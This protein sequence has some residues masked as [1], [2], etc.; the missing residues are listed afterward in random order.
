MLSGITVV[1]FTRHLAGPYCTMRLADL[2]A[3]VIKIEAFP[4]GDPIRTLAP[5]GVD[6]SAYFLSANRNKKS[7][8]L[9]LHDPEGKEIAF[10]LA[11]QADV[12]IESFR[13]GVMQL[14]GL[15]YAEIQQARPDLIYCSLTGYGQSGPMQQL[16]GHDLNYQAVSGFLAVNRDELARPILAEV[17]IADFATG[18][19][20]AEQICAAL[21]QR[22]KRGV[23]TYLDIASVDILSSWMGIHALL[24]S[25]GQD[26]LM[27]EQSRA[28][29]N[30]G[31]YE[32]ADG[33]YVALAAIEEKFW[34]NF[35]R[36]VGR[37]DW[38]ALHNLHI[39]THPDIHEEVKALFLSR[40]QAEWHELGC[41]V[42]CCLT[43][44]EEMDTWLSS[45]YVTSRQLVFTLEGH[46]GEKILQVRTT[47]AEQL[48]HMT[49]PPVLGADT[50]AILSEKLQFTSDKIR[51]YE[52][53]GIIP[54]RVD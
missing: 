34:I 7:I 29:I 8:S 20:A 32:T 1:D 38:E 13:P 12:V 5:G 23:G 42:D 10:A 21:V 53:L 52:R 30:H 15:D 16:G 37:E 48:E 27:T 46:A 54:K 28:M 18:L 40:T 44:V 24:A 45:P 25:Q 14:L 51:K 31:L 9:N 33:R 36:T 50:E 26:G 47:Q 17:P 49:A 22:S 6:S 41:E 39:D 4:G 2:G 43:A 11:A 19:Y 35:C 3:E